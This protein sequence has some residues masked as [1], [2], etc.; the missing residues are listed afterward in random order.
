MPKVRGTKVILVWIPHTG[1][2]GN[3]TVDKLASIEYCTLLRPQAIPPLS[4]L[5]V[6]LKRPTESL[7]A[8]HLI[9]RVRFVRDGFV[10]E[11]ESPSRFLKGGLCRL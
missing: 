3:K 11:T 2:P 7:S 4:L 5:C 9:D 1:I 6:T 10:C 8:T